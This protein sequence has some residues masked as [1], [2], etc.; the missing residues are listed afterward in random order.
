MA[1]KTTRTPRAV[2]LT[3]ALALAAWAEADRALAQALVEFAGLEGATS[4]AQR[5]AAMAMLGQ[6]LL[7]AARRRGLALQ[8]GAGELLPYDPERHELV[9]R[10]QR[11]PNLVRILAPGVVRAGKV[12][13]KARVKAARGEG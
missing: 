7:R 8:G 5:S 10:A 6:S 13:A 4:A 11:P 1:R 3:N 9:T 2:G 12:V